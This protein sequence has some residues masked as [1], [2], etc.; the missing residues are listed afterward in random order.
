MVTLSA[1]LLYSKA[2]V[3]PTVIKSQ[4]TLELLFVYLALKCRKNMCKA[5]C[6]L[7]IKNLF[8]AVDAQIILAWLL[9]SKVNRKNIFV[10]N[11]LKDIDL[12]K[13]EIYA[14]LKVSVKV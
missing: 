6:H 12:L 7:S 9:S 2:K 8:V 13:E 1:F 14:R 3:A 5:F 4:P 11:R 10:A